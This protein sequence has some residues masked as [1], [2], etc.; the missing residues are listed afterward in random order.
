[1]RLRRGWPMIVFVVLVIAVPTF[2]I[3]L[4]VQVGQ[5]IGLLPTLV[6][7]LAEAVFGAWLLNREGSRAWQA[8]LA[9]FRTGR[10]PSGELADAALILVGGVLFMLPG[11]ATDLIGLL[12]LLPMTRPLAR[13]LVA[14]FL[15]R[16]IHRLAGGSL[17]PGGFAGSGGSTVITGETEPA[18][19]TE[20]ASGT[21]PTSGPA[22]DAG[23][24]LIKGELADPDRPA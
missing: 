10:V 15:A 4:L 18:G 20:P 2:E 23:P 22:R 14:F 16:R 11:F 6:I 17:T 5:S 13:R 3:W 19:G 24:M 12:F 1:M 8:L 9:A 21:G 7:L